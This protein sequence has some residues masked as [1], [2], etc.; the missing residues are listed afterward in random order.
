MSGEGVHVND[1]YLDE[2]LDT[3]CHNLWTS[4]RFTLSTVKSDDSQASIK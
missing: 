4:H 3:S 1:S 2:V